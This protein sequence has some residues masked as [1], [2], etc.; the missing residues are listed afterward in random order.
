[1]NKQIQLVQEN[2][3]R[4]SQLLETAT[5][6]KTYDKEKLVK[7]RTEYASYHQELSRLKKQ[8][9]EETYERL[10]YDDER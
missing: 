2:I 3:K 8:Q 10:G 7:L 9:W 5:R 6:D 4:L 1:M